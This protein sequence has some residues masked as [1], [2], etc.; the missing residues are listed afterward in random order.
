MTRSRIFRINAR[1]GQLSAVKGKL[2]VGKYTVG[3][4]AE[5]HGTPKRRT[6]VTCK[7]IVNSRVARFPLV[8]SL[9]NPRPK[10]HENARAGTL[11]TIVSVNKLGVRYSIVG[12]N[13]GL[14]FT[15]S[16]SGRLTVAGALDYEMHR[17]YK[18]V[19]R[20]VVESGGTLELA[21][22]V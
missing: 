14:G 20:A 16:R 15:I 6:K 4:Y 22:E 12:G 9:S 1:T 21:N 8:M 17:E 7:I 19:V 5:D 10:L 13:V 2:R 3:V 11:V 18:L